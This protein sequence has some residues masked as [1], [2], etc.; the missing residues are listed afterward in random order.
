MR[1]PRFGAFLDFSTRA[2][3]KNRLGVLGL[4]I[5]AR[6]SIGSPA[7]A[8][9]P[10][11][12]AGIG[13]YSIAAKENGRTRENGGRIGGLVTLGVDAKNQF[14]VEIGYRF[15]ARFHG[16]DASGGILTLGYRF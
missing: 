15:V 13:T 1:T 14:F 4:G 7:S 16:L 9:Q 11:L 5:Q 3:D 2:D 6:Q 10:Y 12:R 8:V